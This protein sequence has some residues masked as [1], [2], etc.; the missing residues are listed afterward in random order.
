MFPTVAL[1]SVGF[2]GAE[3]RSILSAV[4]LEVFPGTATA[5]VG[6][7]GTG[8]STLARLMVGALAPTRGVIRSDGRSVVYCDQAWS[9]AGDELRI[10]PNWSLGDSRVAL[11]EARTRGVTPGLVV[12][13]EPTRSLDP[14]SAHALG[15]AVRDLVARGAAVVFVSHDRAWTRELADRAV[16]VDKGRV[17]EAAPTEVDFLSIQQRTLETLRS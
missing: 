11:L 3:G 13:D 7:S 9:R 17:T 16:I 5:I 14:K 4:S 1:H 8:K 10:D 15:E 12:L 6:A 2:D